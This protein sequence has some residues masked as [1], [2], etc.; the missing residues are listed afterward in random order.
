MSYG[1]FTIPVEQPA[2]KTRISLSQLVSRLGLDM[3]SWR[4]CHLRWIAED[5]RGRSRHRGGWQSH[6]DQMPRQSP[7]ISNA[8]QEK[9]WIFQS[10]LHLRIIHDRPGSNPSFTV[11]EPGNQRGNANGPHCGSRCAP[12]RTG[13]GG[14]YRADGSPVDRPFICRASRCDNAT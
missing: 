3:R 10:F 11:S 8:R 6:R 9:S 13:R 4:L 7:G 5:G 1:F 12:R 14:G 2:V